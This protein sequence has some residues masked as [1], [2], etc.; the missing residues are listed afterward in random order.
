MVLGS[1]HIAW[2]YDGMATSPHYPRLTQLPR[3]SFFLYGPRGIGN[4]TWARERPG[5][6]YRAGLRDEALYRRLDR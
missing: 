4:S 3:G 5:K 6:A 1:R 2:Y